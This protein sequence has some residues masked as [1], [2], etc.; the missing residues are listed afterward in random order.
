MRG[1]G[2][3]EEE[4]G[5]EEEGEEEEGEEEEGEEEAGGGGEEK[6]GRRRREEEESEGEEEEEEGEGRVVH[7]MNNTY[8]ITA[9]WTPL[10]TRSTERGP[11]VTCALIGMSCNA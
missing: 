5:E 9:L 8:I 1:R 6:E 4:E 10:Q 11:H 3:E 7:F 2:R